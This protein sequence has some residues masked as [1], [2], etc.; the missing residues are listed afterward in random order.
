M[1]LNKEH[2]AEIIRK[3]IADVPRKYKN[4]HEELKKIVDADI[5]KF[6]PLS[7]QAVYENPETRR[8]LCITGSFL[9]RIKSFCNDSDEAIYV[10]TISCHNLSKKSKEQADAILAK[11]SA[12]NNAIKEAKT[13]LQG[14]LAGVKTLKQFK[15]M[16]PELEKY[17]PEEVT[18]SSNLPALANVM[19]GLSSLGWPKGDDK[20]VAA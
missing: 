17:A 2:R 7:V 1:N 3:V 12:E 15:E 13:T 19:A 8:Y 4:L 18:K 16:F 11:A 6:A 5:M 14:A 20:S 9:G 10:N